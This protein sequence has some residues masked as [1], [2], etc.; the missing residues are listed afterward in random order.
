MLPEEAKTWNRN[1]SYSKTIKPKPTKNRR[2]GIL[3]KQIVQFLPLHPLETTGTSTNLGTS[4]S[5]SHCLLLSLLAQSP[6]S[7]TFDEVQC[8]SSPHFLCVFFGWNQCLIFDQLKGCLKPSTQNPTRCNKTFISHRLWTAVSRVCQVSV[9]RTEIANSLRSA[10]YLPESYAENR[11]LDFTPPTCSHKREFKN[12][13]NDG[14]IWFIL[15]L[16][17]H[18]AE[19]NKAVSTVQRQSY[20]H[21]QTATRS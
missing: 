6:K 18:E 17:S 13:L 12:L 3:M 11:C 7:Q 1:R 16:L 15:I 10:K 4:L 14:S 5:S 9:S 19:F 21:G 8:H 20:K 2:I